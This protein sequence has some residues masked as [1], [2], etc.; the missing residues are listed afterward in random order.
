M[1]DCEC[2]IHPFQNDPGTS[3]SQR[4]M[5]ELLSG[6][7]KI[8]ART[9]ADLLN[10]FVQ[11]SRHINYYD[12]ELNISDWQ[13]FFRNSIPFTL[14]SIIKNQSADIE[15]NF[16]YYNSL[17]E[18]KPSPS[19]VQLHAYFIFY[20]FIN[21]INNWHL[22]VK[23]SGLPIESFL[24]ILIKDKLQQPVKSFVG[25]ANAAVKFYGIKKIDFSKLYDNEVW[26]IEVTD[27]YIIDNSFKT[28]TNSK[29]KQLNNLYRQFIAIMPPF[30]DAIKIIS[31]EAEN[32]LEQSLLPLKEEL[33]KKHPPHL[34]LLFA[35]LNIFRYLQDD[36][37]GYTRKHLD[38]FYKDVLQIKSRDAIADK[39]HIIFEIQKQLQKYLIKK[40]ILVKDG[41]D[42]NKQEILFSL[43]DEIVV[44]KTK[45]IETRTLFLNSQSAFAQSY[46][47]G[48]YIANDATKADGIDK[49][50]KDKQPKNFPTLGA[51][52]SK[53]S[54][55][56]T[57][58]IR[59]Y[60]N[61]RLGFILGSPVLYLKE[62][63][64]TVDITL[65]CQLKD[66]ICADIGSEIIEA[67]KNCCDDAAGTGTTNDKNQYP[68]FL[69]AEEIFSQVQADIQKKFIYLG[70]EVFK[71]A[72]AKGFDKDFIQ[73]IRENFLIAEQEFVPCY[74][75]VHTY[76]TEG[77]VFSNDWN[78]FINPIVTDIN[79]RK[80]LDE[81]FKPETVLNVLFSGEKNWIEP[82]VTN[83][84]IGNLF[85]NT[86]ILT[87]SATINPEQPSIIYYDKEKLKEDFDT[88][89]PLVK[90]ELNDR[91]KI[92]WAIIPQ[93]PNQDRIAGCCDQDERCCL[94]KND[95]KPPQIISFYY[96]FRNIEVLKNIGTDNTRIDV[97]VCGLKNFIVQ[98]DES[99]QD[100]NGPV[101]P[102]G[103]RPVIRN[104]D[105]YTL[106]IVHD[107]SNSGPTFYIGSKEIFCKKWVSVRINLN[108]KDKPNDFREY[109]K[110]YVV[111]DPSATPQVFGL[112][113]DKFLIKISS[114]I[115]GIWNEELGFRKLFDAVPPDSLP[116]LPP[117]TFACDHED[118]FSQG[119]LIFASDFG[120]SG[121]QFCISDPDFEKLAVSTRNG[122]IK[123]NLRDQDFLHKDYAFVLSRQMMALGRYPDALLEGAV[124]KVDG[125]TVI[126]FRSTGKT[127]VELKDDINDTKDK[128]QLSKNK[129][130]ELNTAFDN[131][132]DL[133]S[134]P[135]L[136][137][138]DDGERDTLFPLVI[139]NNTLA[140]D[141]LQQALE[142]QSKLG[143]LQALLNIFDVFTGEI[144]KPLTV[145]IPNEPWT[146]IIGNM[147]L[148]YTATATLEDIDLIH[149]YPYTGTYR[150]EEIKLQPTLLP[151]F[152][153]EGTLFLGLKNL[154]PG[155][156]LNIL[157][158]IAEATSD[159]ESQKEDVQWH[160]LDSNVWKP[161]RKGFEVLDDASENLT[162]SGIVKFA[163][164]ANM[165]KDNT[166]MPKALHWIKASIPQNSKAVSETTGIY[167][168]AIRVT[169]TNDAANDK[170][171]LSQPLAAGSISKL[172]VADA[173][174]KSVQQPYDTFDGSI[175]EIEQQFYVRV[176]EG[177]RHKG[178]AIQK[179]DYE[180]LALEAFPQLFKAKCINH[181]F[182]LD[183]HLYKN[184]FP[185]APGYIILAVIPDLYKLKAGNSFEPKVPV[186]IIEKI[187]TYIR[188]RTS[189]FV[190][191]RAMNPRYEK[192]NFCLRVKLLEGKDENYYREKLKQDLKELLAPWAVGKYDKLTF[193][194]CVYRS[195][196]IRFLENTDY[197]DFINDFRMGK[198]N[199]IPVD[200]SSKICPDTPRSIMIAGDIEIYI[201]QPDCEDWKICRDP[202]Q[203][204][205]D[206]CTT[207]LI[208]VVDYCIDKNNMIG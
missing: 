129:A 176:S 145:L 170:L 146:P 55:P 52:L 43:D 71:R 148:D 90:I 44:N 201:D 133:A 23:D 178:R 162:T 180:R 5:N 200:T 177:L 48:V 139:S 89:Q 93:L 27:L 88:T 94:L 122:F 39:A 9:L 26:N 160:Y 76:K 64:R 77:S 84:T 193:G 132:I 87:I 38:F 56:E 163:M 109:Y 111:E 174:V 149:L 120:F 63:T 108:W 70:E 164:P 18:K 35:F 65:A 157:F 158:Q 194:Q 156:S 117:N 136:D 159:S 184:D 110:G 58:T 24:E 72:I 155:N 142:T 199:Q 138:I 151:T 175:P 46:V 97:Q 1:Y 113:Q 187:E 85:S 206:C 106:P 128:A 68:D 114:L 140:D 202:N 144:V 30:F 95:N 36:L 4:V 107:T 196:I 101:Y 31:A 69:N 189:P 135:P 61:A 123:I 20:R 131:A 40:G 197:V 126:V 21:K 54:D 204:K 152:C 3:Q 16:T 183:A 53:Y 73:Q 166:I 112:D 8:D 42:N 103:T 81:I 181:S 25:Y 12:A 125:N 51:K 57:N 99:L 59:P 19:G 75:D 47:E 143:D 82:A 11:L 186:S 32:N 10:Y 141:T 66:S 105:I 102:F 45:I 173:F 182:A 7:A 50:F 203:N 17:F 37:N 116:L 119:I 137:S 165:T 161:L 115:D 67:S 29:F 22:A 60:A 154:I 190:R 147:S 168:Q 6:A 74:C 169:F 78:A 172:N 208:P 134:A 79:R 80:L 130:D 98:N 86:F 205:I 167:P 100:V 188:K 191:F 104:F 121:R 15:N 28:G 192:I 92:Q 124:Y 33:Q 62:G 83:I 179:F 207:P 198:E 91:L 41:K 14:A 195:D 49:D 153:D 127:I 118:I 150:H 13:P 34:G 2:L 185:Y 96:F 171:R